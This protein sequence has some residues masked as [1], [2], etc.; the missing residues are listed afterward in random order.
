M[1]RLANVLIPL[2]KKIEQGE[3]SFL[4]RVGNNGNTAGCTGGAFLVLDN[5]IRFVI[6]QI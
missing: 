2:P 6:I 3:G 1:R 5:D 4:A